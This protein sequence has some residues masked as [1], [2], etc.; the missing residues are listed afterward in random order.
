MSIKLEL[1]GGVSGNSTGGWRSRLNSKDEIYS[2]GRDGGLSPGD[3]Q[4]R[5]Q[6]Q[7]AMAAGS[8][9]SSSS[10]SSALALNNVNDMNNTSPDDISIARFT[11]DARILAARSEYFRFMLEVTASTASTFAEGVSR[12]ITI[13]DVVS[14][15]AF[16]A[17]L[18]YIH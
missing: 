17:V 18:H 15:R 7:M 6:Q 9:S 10:S 11:A 14:V 5:G 2:L 4:Y 3:S 16:Q 1:Q 12:E 13:K 8:S